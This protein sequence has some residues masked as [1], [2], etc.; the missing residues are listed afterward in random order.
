MEALVFGDGGSPL[1]VFPTSMGKFFEYEDRGMIG[2]L[3]GKLIVASCRCSVPTR[4]IRRAGTTRVFI[5]D[6]V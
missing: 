5:R 3:A 4:W 2:A 1:V 6:S